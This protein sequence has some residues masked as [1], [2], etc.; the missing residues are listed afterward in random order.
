[1][2]L[3]PDF[4]KGGNLLLVLALVDQLPSVGDLLRGQFR[5]TAEFHAPELRG[6][7]PGAGPFAD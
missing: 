7:H 6:L 2:G 5:L 4:E 1:M 3:P